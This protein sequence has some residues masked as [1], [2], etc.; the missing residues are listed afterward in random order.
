MELSPLV[1]I[2]LGLFL[3]IFGPL[4]ISAAQLSLRSR[5][6]ALKQ[7]DSI[8][9]SATFVALLVSVLALVA[10]GWSYLLMREVRFLMQ[11]GLAL[12]IVIGSALVIRRSL[13]AQQITLRQAVE[14]TTSQLMMLTGLLMTLSG[15]FALVTF[16]FLSGA[17]QGFE[18]IRNS[19][20]ILGVAG[21]FMTIAFLLFNLFFAEQ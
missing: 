21:G 6:G 9:I 4:V 3:L 10:S 2:L 19:V 16:P 7:E 17:S 18:Q 1:D 5:Q 20:L 14:V 12:L 8:Q 15:L 11:T 13:R